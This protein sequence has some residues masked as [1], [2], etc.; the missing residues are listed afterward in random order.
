LDVGDG[1]SYSGDDLMRVAN[2]Q[3][4]ALPAGGAVMNLGTSPPAA[5]PTSPFGS[6][7]PVAVAG[8]GGAG[9]PMSP[10]DSHAALIAAMSAAVASSGPPLIPVTP[11]AAP[12]VAPLPVAGGAVV[13][14]PLSNGGT[15]API[16]IG[17]LA[18]SVNT[19]DAHG[20]TLLFA[21]CRNGK[22]DSVVLLL[23]HGATIDW[24]NNNGTTPLL[25]AVKAV[26]RTLIYTLSLFRPLIPVIFL[27][28]G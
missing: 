11:P 19:P 23:D 2:G 6:G 22:L 27:Q 21:S 26:C 4:V 5:T 8:P 9:G 1:H 17:S 15:G 24:V 10:R 12:V 18:S 28:T 25:Q 14:A 7:Q 20:E 3:S 16:T 13:A